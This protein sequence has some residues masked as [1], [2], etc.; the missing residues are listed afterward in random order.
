MR[1]FACNPSTCKD[2]CTASKLPTF[3]LHNEKASPKSPRHA[4]SFG[5]QQNKGAIFPYILILIFCALSQHASAFAFIGKPVSSGL[6][7][8]SRSSEI[9]IDS[10]IPASATVV[11][12]GHDSPSDDNTM[13]LRKRQMQ[14]PTSPFP[15]PF[16]GGLGNNFTSPSC[17]LFFTNFLNDPNF[18]ACHVVSLLLVVSPYQSSKL[19]IQADVDYFRHLR[20][21]FKLAGTPIA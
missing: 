7:F 16:D 20:A 4:P 19:Q 18:Q 17:P 21:F 12:A 5:Y 13:E 9:L 1:G 14:S 3:A 11:R 8:S 2:P 10:S 6:G 15:T